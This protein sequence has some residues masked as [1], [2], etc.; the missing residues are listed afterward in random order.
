M[1]SERM[2]PLELKSDRAANLVFMIKGLHKSTPAMLA[3][4]KNAFFQVAEK[5][6][7]WIGLREPNELSDRWIG[8]AGYTPKPMSCKAKSADNPRFRLAGLVVDPTLCPEAFLP[9]SLPDAISKWNHKFAPG[10]RLPAGYT[11]VTAGN[12]KG[13]VRLH[14]SA[15]HADFDLMTITLAGEDGGMAFTSRAQMQD[16]VT[17]V[18]PQL[19]S[20]LRTPMI[21]HGPEFDYDAGVGARDSEQVFFFGPNRRFILSHSSMPTTPGTMH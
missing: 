2:N 9:A 12:D 1:L 14:G 10:G 11:R 4:H 15:I 13:L 16:L 20:L 7:C 8:L 6:K 5:L 3:H 18:Q 21:Q 17:K 19:N